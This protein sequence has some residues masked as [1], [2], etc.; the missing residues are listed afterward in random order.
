MTDDSNTDAKLLLTL[1]PVLLVADLAA[2][3]RYY[4]ETL[5]FQKDW[6]YGNPVFYASISRDQITF[7]LRHVDTPPSLSPRSADIIDFYITV[8]S[9]D[10]LYSELSGRGAN[11]VYGPAKQDYGMKEFYIEDCNGYRLGF[12]QPI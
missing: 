2:T 9:V 5:G 12:G 6:D 4:Q 8:A 10:L 11:V 1:T 7:N 3:L